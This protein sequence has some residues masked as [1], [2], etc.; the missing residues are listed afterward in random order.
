[1]EFPYEQC[2]ECNKLE[3]NNCNLYKE[4][5]MGHLYQI[6]LILILEFLNFVLENRRGGLPWGISQRII[7]YEMNCPKK[8]GRRPVDQLYVIMGNDGSTSHYQKS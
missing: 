2:S 3:N 6:M 4:L 1:M 8:N 7:E 5:L